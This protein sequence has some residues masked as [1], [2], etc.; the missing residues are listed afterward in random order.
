MQ[1]L[2]GTAIDQCME[3]VAS[4]SDISYQE[5]ERVVRHQW[6]SVLVATRTSW[7]I[8]LTGLGYL[9]CSQRKI[10]RRLAAAYRFLEHYWR[11]F[12]LV[13]TEPKRIS[14]QTR[15][16]SCEQLIEKYQLKLARN[17]SRLERAPARRIQQLCRQPVDKGVGSTPV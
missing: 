8:E 1:K 10:E 11:Q 2:K 5:V 12:P 6:K 3:L 4:T 13:N 9:V 17:E 7:T 14:L 15:I 16:K